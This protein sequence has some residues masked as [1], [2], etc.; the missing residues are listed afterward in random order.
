MWRRRVRY[1]TNFREACT[2]S[3]FCI[4]SKE[5]ISAR[6]SHFFRLVVDYRYD[7]VRQ[8]GVTTIIKNDLHACPKT[9]GDCQGG[10]RNSANWLPSI[11]ERKVLSGYVN[12]VQ[13]RAS[14]SVKR[15][16]TAVRGAR[17]LI[18]GMPMINVRQ[19][20]ELFRDASESIY[21]RSRSRGYTTSPLS[22]N[23]FLFLFSCFH[24][25]LKAFSRNNIQIRVQH[26]VKIYL[27]FF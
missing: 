5:K 1:E 2:R 27:F 21:S 7:T 3:T 20:T 10:F 11:Q 22:R 23:W 13:V 4:L 6:C 14:V 12:V 9:S 25:F 17:R 24:R 18:T 26:F 8:R 15:T 19:M 16:D